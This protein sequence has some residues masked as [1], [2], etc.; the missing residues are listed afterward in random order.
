MTALLLTL[1]TLSLALLGA[2][3]YRASLWPVAALCGLLLVLLWT[4]RRPWAATLVQWCLVLGAVEW[5]R[6]VLV[7]VQQRMTMGQAWHRLAL[8]LLAV[9]VF[10][11]ASALV[12]RHPRL[13]QRFAR[14]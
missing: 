9:A 10:T 1:P 14:A 4:L 5:L 6:T 11:A 13:R 2:H 7:L 3:F 8:I 12:F